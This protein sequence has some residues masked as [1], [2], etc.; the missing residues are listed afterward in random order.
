MGFSLLP[1]SLSRSD[2]GHFIPFYFSSFFLIYSVP[3]FIDK[4]LARHFNKL[5]FLIKFTSLILITSFIIFELKNTSLSNSC[6]NFN[7]D[8]P[9]SIFVG[10]AQYDRFTLN[11]PLLY[12]NYSYL[13]PA[14]K[15]ISDE[16]GL[17]NTCAI[18]DEI[19]NDLV[20]APKPTIFFINKTLI[21]DKNNKVLYSNCGKI[22]EYI[23]N[24]TKIIGQ[25][26]LSDYN[27]DVRLSK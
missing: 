16:P 9:K 14:T 27:L 1:P 20:S 21:T 12:L 10:N 24:H 5:L 2:I 15:Y 6:S 17:Q 7:V 8:N 3:V 19:I 26:I 23:I 22:E 13:K 11:F 25:C 4:Y 18:G